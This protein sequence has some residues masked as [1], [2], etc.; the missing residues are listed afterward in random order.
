MTKGFIDPVTRKDVYNHHI[1]PNLA[2][3]Q[4]I[5]MHPKLKQWEKYE[6]DFIH[7]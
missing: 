1:F 6:Y 7:N 2:L 3:E 4:Y 5:R